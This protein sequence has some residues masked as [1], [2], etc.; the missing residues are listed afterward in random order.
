L[1]T[2]IARGELWYTEIVGR[3]GDKYDFALSLHIA[4][5]HEELCCTGIIGCLLAAQRAAC[6]SFANHLV[7]A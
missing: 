4:S 5:F 3:V 7:N 1:F 6:V 2:A